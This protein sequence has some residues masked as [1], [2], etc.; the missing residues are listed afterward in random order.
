MRGRPPVRLALAA[1]RSTS[2]TARA[3]AAGSRSLTTRTRTRLGVTTTPPTRGGSGRGRRWMLTKR[4]LTSGSSGSARPRTA[5]TASRSPPLAAARTA[6][7]TSSRCSS[8]R[9][10][11]R[12]CGAPSAAART[13]PSGTRAAYWTSRSRPA[14]PPCASTSSRCSCVRGWRPRRPSSRIQ[15][16]LA[17]RAARLCLKMAA[18]A[19]ARPGPPPLGSGG[20]RR[21]WA[22]R[23]SHKPRMTPP[24]SASRRIPPLT[25]P[26]LSRAT[27]RPP[28]RPG[29]AEGAVARVAQGA[30]AVAAVAGEG[31]APT[32]RRPEQ[33]S[34]T[35]RRRPR[36]L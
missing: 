11:T 9:R 7:G 10:P 33:S 13:S 20:Y 27:H 3:R 14:P 36:G 16:K 32:H 23:L 17:A 5:S 15:F 29:G 34:Q 18:Q 30:A 22:P 8:P 35:S 24:W 19:P 12:W 6:R 26:S 28:S 4:G 2:S 31:A 1:S 21:A 25:G